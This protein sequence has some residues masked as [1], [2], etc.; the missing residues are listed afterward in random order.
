MR[1]SNSNYEFRNSFQLTCM[2]SMTL[3]GLKDIF[4]FHNIS[5]ILS[6]NFAKFSEDESV[7]KKVSCSVTKHISASQEKIRGKSDSLEWLLL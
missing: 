7:L 4:S 2:V 1:N 6:V 3:N 5:E